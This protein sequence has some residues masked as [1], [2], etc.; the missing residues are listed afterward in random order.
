MAERNRLNERQRLALMAYLIRQR[1]TMAQLWRHEAAVNINQSGALPFMVTPRNLERVEAML[2]HLPEAERVFFRKPAPKPKKQQQ[3]D[4]IERRLTQL[5][6]HV[7][8]LAQLCQGDL[9]K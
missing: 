8:R 5:E 3:A 1:E 9:F 6:A 4:D 7:A 2:Q